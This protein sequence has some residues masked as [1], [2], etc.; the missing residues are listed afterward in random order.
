[1]G[2]PSGNPLGKNPSDVWEL[3]TKEW[4]EA[5]WDIPNVKSNHPEKTEHP[6]QYPV[7]LVERCVLALTKPG[8]WVFDPYLGTG[9]AIVAAIRHNRRGAGS[10]VVGAYTRIAR[11][12]IESAAAGTLRTR[13]MNRPVY[14]HTKAGSGM[15]RPPWLEQKRR[16]VEMPLMASSSIGK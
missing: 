10:D 16:D 14:D 3:L 13:P 11:E 5:L 2:K 4:E 12:R 15:T 7:E 1:M 6:C 9:T 8:D